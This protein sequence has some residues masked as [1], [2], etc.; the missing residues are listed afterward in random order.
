[1][2]ISDRAFRALARAEPNVIATLLQVVAP[3]SV[4]PN[5]VL[6]PDDVAASQLDPVPAPLDVDW[7]ARAADDVIHVECQGYRDA[8]FVERLFWYHLLLVLRHRTRRVR[9][10]AIWVT[11]PS[12]TQRVEAFEHGDVTVRMTTVVLEDVPAAA[13][14]E[15]G[16]TACFAPGADA[17]GLSDA[18]LCQRAAAR[19][20]ESGAGYYQRHMAVVA[21]TTAGRY[22]EMVKA[23]NDHN[24]EPVIIEDLVRFGEDRGR[25]EG[26]EE[27]LF[28]LVRLIER[29][30]G[31]S[32]AGTEHRTLLDRL[33]SLGPERLGDVVL[34]CDGV[35]LG[36]WL[37]DRGA[38]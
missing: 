30:L 13:L 32:L 27:R 15:R 28:P 35:Q 2:A 6:T 34:D 37:A 3:M 16:E 31:R 36:A 10:I 8:G 11:R 26:R 21:A 22:E 14:L 25:E 12:R 19:M 1:M 20:A 18:D 5:V 38:R 33:K 17:G 24:L 7:V 4:P 29:K 23:M 9:S